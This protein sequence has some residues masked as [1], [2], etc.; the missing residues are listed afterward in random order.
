MFSSLPL[1]PQMNAAFEFYRRSLHRNADVAG[2]QLC[3]SRHRI[4]Y[5]AFDIFQTDLGFDDQQI[6]DADDSCQL[7]HSPFSV[8]FLILPL[9]FT[10]K[11]DPSLLYLDLYLVF[12]NV[13]IPADDVQAA[14]R[15]DVICDISI[16]WYP[17]FDFF[18]NS[19]YAF[20][21]LYRAFGSDFFSVGPDMSGEA[22]NPIFYSDTYSRSI[23]VG[24]KLKLI[25]NISAQL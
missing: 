1:S 4:F 23:N 19:M 8:F 17:D 20:N 3:I 10:F 5:A 13:G 6:V 15:Y 22:D 25:E 12:W 16:A 14:G 9:H 18:G 21:A 7:T 11:R 2:I 24:L